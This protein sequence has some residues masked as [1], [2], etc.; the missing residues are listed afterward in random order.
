[1]KA[2]LSIQEYD[3]QDRSQTSALSPQVTA[4][5][6]Y[7]SLAENGNE[8][9][10]TPAP[11]RSSEDKKRLLSGFV[12]LHNELLD[13]DTWMSLRDVSQTYP[14]RIAADVRLEAPQRSV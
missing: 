14:R 6:A 4:S 13:R 10:S 7:L 8:C 2:D 3:V 12:K 5:D 1:M 11:S 9:T